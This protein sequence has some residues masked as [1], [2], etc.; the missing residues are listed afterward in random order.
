MLNIF[1]IIVVA[2][3][4]EIIHDQMKEDVSSSKSTK[5][6][7]IISQDTTWND[8][9]ELS[10]N[11]IVNSGVTLTINNQITIKGDVTISG[12]GIIRRTNDYYGIVI[13]VPQNS[14]LR[15]EN[16]IFDGDVVYGEYN[17]ATLAGDTKLKPLAEFLGYDFTQR[18]GKDGTALLIDIN[19][20]KLIMDKGT[21][22]KNN[23][24]STNART[25]YYSAY[26]NNCNGVGIRAG[27]NFIMNGGV[28]TDMYGSSIASTK[29]EGNSFVMNGGKITHSYG[30]AIIV[31]ENS[32]MTMNG[33]EISYCAREQNNAIGIRG[34]DSKFI[35]NGGEICYNFGSAASYGTIMANNGNNQIVDLL[36][37]KIHNNKGSYGTAIVTYNN[38]KTH[39]GGDVEIYSNGPGTTTTTNCIWIGDNGILLVDGNANIHDN[40]AN[41][42]VLSDGQ[43]VFADNAKIEKNNSKNSPA[44]TVRNGELTIKDKASVSNNVSEGTNGVGIKVAAGKKLNVLGGYI[45]NNTVYKTNGVYDRGAGVY[46]ETK[47]SIL[48]IGGNATIFGNKIYMVDSAEKVTEDTDFADV[49]IDLYDSRILNVVS[50][51]T[52]DGYIG[53]F[54]SKEITDGTILV[55]GN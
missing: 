33:G 54:S 1:P 31:N 32:T 7:Q 26:P 43:C 52:T 20:G 19:G 12:G 5:A 36:G 55:K 17:E 11:L 28:I 21:V 14:K 22:L 45:T 29:E 10:E 25:N 15:L 46:L 48:N 42:T 3:D 30:L 44:V 49:D 40:T 16:I 34:N 13:E 50:S 53:I 37:G 2:Q 6:S 4:N 9:V 41:P 51:L 38:T 18:T 8:K 23:S 35:M 39:I 24:T 27:G 47:D